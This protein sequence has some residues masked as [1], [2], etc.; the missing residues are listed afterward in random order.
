MRD[1]DRFTEIRKSDFPE[2]FP[3]SALITMS[4]FGR[5]PGLMVEIQAIAVVDHE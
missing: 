2:G 4:G 3:A 1:G 5:N